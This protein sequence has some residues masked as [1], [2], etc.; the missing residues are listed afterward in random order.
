M[1]LSDE[2]AVKRTMWALERTQLAWI[3]TTFAIT[4]AGIAID[5]GAM[6]L[7]QA[8]YVQSPSL[9]SYSFYIGSTLAI[10][11]TVQLAAST[12]QYVRRNRELMVLSGLAPSRVPAALPISLLVALLNIGVVA[13]VVFFR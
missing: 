12:V 10:Y 4:S 7:K 6:A 13:F 3:R 8:N 2:L 9:V 1:N 11:A 5:K